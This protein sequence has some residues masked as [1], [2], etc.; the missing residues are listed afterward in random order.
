M[1]GYLHQAVT[2]RKN[3]SLK[4]RPNLEL[5]EQA[6]RVA[7]DRANADVKPLGDLFVAQA[8]GQGLQDVALPGCELGDHELRLAGLAARA[9]DVPDGLYHLPLREQLLPRVEAADRVRDVI[10]TARLL[11]DA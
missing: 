7:A 11:Q 2:H 5:G 4:P 10:D 8:L 6:G 9:A 1:L 3:E